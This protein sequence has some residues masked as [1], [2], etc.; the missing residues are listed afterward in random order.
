MNVVPYTDR[1]GKRG[2]G[3]KQLFKN[4]ISGEVIF[5]DS[6]EMHLKGNRDTIPI[7]DALDS[8]GRKL[9]PSYFPR[10]SS[11]FHRDTKTAQKRLVGISSKFD[12]TK[13]SLD[14]FARK[15]M[16]NLREKF[17]ELKHQAPLTSYKKN[18]SPGAFIPKDTLK[19]NTKN[20][21][22]LKSSPLISFRGAYIS[23]DFSYRSNLDTPFAEKNL[24]QHISTGNLNF[25]ILNKFP[26]R[27]TYLVRLSN[28]SFFRDIY[29]A[30][31]EFDV[32]T[33]RNQLDS[34]FRDQLAQRIDGIKD[35]L[36]EQLYNNKLN[37]FK[38][39]K[40]WLQ[41]PFTYQRLYEMNE[42]VRM[43][44]ITYDQTLP[45]SVAKGRSDSLQNLAKLFLELYAQKNEL[46]KTLTGEVDSLRN[47][48]KKSKEEIDQ[49]KQFTNGGNHS[50]KSIEEWKSNL[51]KFSGNTIQIPKEYQWLLGVRNMSIG[52]TQLNQSELTAKN[53]SL[54][55]VNFEYNTWY[56]LAFSA[57][58]VDYR[59]RDF[60]F[61]PGKIP[62][63]Y[64]S[65][66]RIGLG[67]LERNYFITSVFKGQK[68]L[69]SSG[70][71]SRGVQPVQVSGVSFEG[72]YQFARNAFFVAEA[73][74]SFAPNLNGDTVS[75]KGFFDLSD[76]RNKAISLKLFSYIPRSNSRIEAMYKYTGANYQSFSIYHGNVASTWW[77]IKLDQN[78]FKRA[79]KISAAIKSNE[80]SNPYV[81]QNYNSSNIFKSVMLTYRKRKM[82]IIS[83][84]YLPISQFIR[85][86][87]QL[88][89]SKFQT[90]NASLNHLYKLGDKQ[91][92]TT[93]VF[94]RF[95][96]KSVDSAFTYYNAV[97]FLVGQA[98]F[99]KSF[100]ATLNLIQTRNPNYKLNVL[101]GSVQVPVSSLFSFGAGAKVNT[102]N[103][104]DLKVG[105]YGSVQFR[106]RNMD[107][108]YMSFDK[109]YLTGLNHRLINN[110]FVNVGISKYFK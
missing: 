26:I 110:D 84:G 76:H 33:F 109:G 35:S 34:R 21:S 25:P 38:K 89:E 7:K 90:F 23:Y 10:D 82:P 94:N 69:Y 97:N 6:I 107:V 30:R 81:I 2:V 95:Y 83:I 106:F 43:P 4:K 44:S 103:K 93:V 57:G 59:F 92:S 9:L 77:Y 75:T 60:S 37:E 78:L 49:L 64:V 27:V 41:D 85:L 48:V 101:D 42:I 70:S 63:Q 22:D 32:A 14:T 40:E 45:D 52:K 96:N 86:N 11:N 61:Q 74:Q 80:F 39:L 72:K 12:S 98:F 104:E 73:A 88:V 51:N 108:L 79:L 24:S 56:Y 36:P 71:L 58:L 3:Y 29:D 5:D 15:A 100:N 50:W 87:N 16:A 65:M 67:E 17:V 105:F 53:L 68:Q 99:L 8:I 91:A 66:L 54:T 55:G 28:S 20:L 18:F 46:Y 102:L 19:W 62:F 1:S 47:V 31:V 13:H